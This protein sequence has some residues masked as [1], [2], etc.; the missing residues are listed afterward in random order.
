MK[1]KKLTS[2]YLS[3]LLS[4]VKNYQMC[5]AGANWGWWE[6]EVCTSVN[7]VLR[8][9]QMGAVSGVGSEQ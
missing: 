7:Y 6:A 1:T 8:R 9:A 4:I 3:L 5:F 2:N